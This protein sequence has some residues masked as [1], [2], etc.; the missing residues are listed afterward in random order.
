M[1]KKILCN[2]WWKFKFKTDLNS[3]ETIQNVRFYEKPFRFLAMEHFHIPFVPYWS[4]DTP[5][6]KLIKINNYPIH[7]VTRMEDWRYK[8][9]NDF[10][11]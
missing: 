8:V 4:I 3:I 2:L 1:N 6:G 7:R 5:Q 11:R 10:D 9:E